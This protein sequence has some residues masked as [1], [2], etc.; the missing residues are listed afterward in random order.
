MALTDIQ[1]A[2]LKLL[3]NNRR[4]A[5][6]SY[7]AG[8]LAL[9]YKLKT[10]RV[11]RDIDVFNDTREALFTSWEADKKALLA[12]GYSVKPLRILETFVEA[13]VCKNNQS[14]EI[15]WAVDSAF[16]FFPLVEDDEVGFT[17]HPVDLATNKLLALVGRTEVR[18]WIDAISA[19][20]NLQPMAY[21]LSACC[22]KDPGFSPLSMLEYVA[23]RRYNQLEIDMQIVPKGEY[24][25][26]TLC[27][28]WHE[29]VDRAHEI[30]K[31]FPRDKVGSV[32]L[33]KDGVLF[34]GDAVAFIKALDADEIVFHQGHIG[35][36]WPRI[37]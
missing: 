16:R 10:P 23:R 20:Q 2:I 3:S 5:T 12:D 25:A 22:G 17:L 8:G 32:V 11:S 37:R 27:R 7:V 35:G 33:S 30:L 18:D 13:E 34:K 6:N 36:V 31:V 14:V 26:A 1:C 19:I 28:F 21:L 29:E 4:I 15:Q 9:N 24:D